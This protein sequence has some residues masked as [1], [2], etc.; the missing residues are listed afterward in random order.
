MNWDFWIASQTGKYICPG[1]GAYMVFEDENR[2][3]LVCEDCGESMDIDD[4]GVE[5]PGWFPTLQELMGDD[6]NDDNDDD[7]D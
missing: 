5:D 6:D 2:S 4:Y 7:D 3:I 1:C